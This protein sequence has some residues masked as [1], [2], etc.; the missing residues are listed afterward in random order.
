MA[1]GSSGKRVGRGQGW[2]C[3]KA[4]SLWFPLLL[5]WCTGS[6]RIAYKQQHEWTELQLSFL[7]CCLGGARVVGGQS[8]LQQLPSLSA[9]HL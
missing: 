1:V 2:C 5:S 8:M 4:F 7:L 9:D 6:C 3:V